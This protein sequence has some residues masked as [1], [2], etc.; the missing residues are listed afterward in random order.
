MGNDTTVL[1]VPI[2]RVT[3]MED[4]AQVER[5]GRVRLRGGRETWRVDKVSPVAVDRSLQVQ[6]DGATLV[7]ARIVRTWKEKPKGGLPADATELRKRVKAQEEEVAAVRAKVDRLAAHEAVVTTA[8][9][10]ALR[11]IRESAGT[12][13]SD[14]SQWNKLLGQ[15]REAKTKVRDNQRAAGCQLE[16]AQRRLGELKLALAQGEQPVA[17]LEVSVELVAESQG[18]EAE[19]KIGYL[20]PCGLWRPAYRASLTK[21]AE[22]KSTV[23][24]ES[25]AVVWQRTG[26]DWKDVALAFS[27]ARPTLGAAPPN[28]AEDRLALRDKTEQEKKTIE[29]AVRE[30]VIQT[31]GEGGKS[32]LAEM[33]GLDDGGEV[34]VL[35]AAGKGS[36]PSDGEPHRVPLFGFEANA[37]TELLCAPEQS[38]RIS[39]VVRF[40][41]RGPQVLLAG[42]VDLVRA[43]GFVG[44]GQVKFAAVGET[45]KLSLGSE[46]ALRVSRNVVEERAVAKLTGKKTLTRN[47]KL[48]VSNA[49]GDAAQIAIEERIPVSEVEA[50]EV[51]FLKNKSDKPAKISP[52]GIVRFELDLAA[53]QQREVAFAYEVVGSAKVTGL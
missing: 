5:R 42:P 28:L 26:E 1:D 18:G 12:G 29:V 31:A 37:L 24:L 25:E 16:R 8:F 40:E 11:N 46:D 4:R 15:V 50:V 32:K 27:T 21:G 39:L 35:S 38:P 22:A 47:V 6:L 17:E 34:R 19:L 53:R 48:F 44:R 13:K 23:R 52:D 36:V 30:E 41:N 43:S 9:E 49:G 10:D 45:V 7:D 33:P 2:V 20:V 14:A 51:N 3:C